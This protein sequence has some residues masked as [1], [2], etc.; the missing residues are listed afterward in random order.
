MMKNKIAKDRKRG[1]KERKPKRVILVSYEGNNKTEKTYLENFKS[2]DKPYRI[3]EVPG[4]GT[5]PVSLVQQTNEKV[6]KENLDLKSYDKAY[7]IFDTDA[8]REKEKEIEK[9][10][11]FANKKKIIPIVSTPCIELWFLLHYEL[12]TAEL[13]NKRVIEKLKKHCHK[14][15]KNYNIYDD[16]K[17]FTNDAIKR[18]KKL[19]KHQIEN[20]K[21]LQTIEA[22][23]YTEMYKLVEELIK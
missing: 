22:N 19:E 11:N 7:C 15:E 17:K 20:G 14:Y 23:P 3:I 2:R 12:T 1:T 8:K 16:I 6:K 21:K 10:I 18:A 9:T 13:T 4:N 5:D